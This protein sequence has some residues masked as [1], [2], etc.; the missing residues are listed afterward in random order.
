M[1]AGKTLNQQKLRERLEKS[2]ARIDDLEAKS[3]QA[4][5]S[6]RARFLD[7]VDALRKQQAQLETDLNKLKAEAQ[8]SAATISEG[9]DAV[10]ES[11]E[12]RIESIASRLKHAMHKDGDRG[13]SY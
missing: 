7:E 6:A 12:K 2:A 13:T 1:K 5:S 8:V 3:R 9:I 4:H 11:L 10:Y